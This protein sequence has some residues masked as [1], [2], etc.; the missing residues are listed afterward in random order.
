MKCNYLKELA[1]GRKIEME[2]GHLFPKSIREKM[3][4]S[5]A[6]D[7]ILEAPCYYSRGLIPMERKLK[8]K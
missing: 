7:H 6:K 1:L 3:I 2:H 4:N 5:I 8:G